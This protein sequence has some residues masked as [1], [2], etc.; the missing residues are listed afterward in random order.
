MSG[1]QKGQN[2]AKSH[3]RLTLK[4]KYIYIFF[5]WN[6]PNSVSS[7]QFREFRDFSAITENHWPYPLQEKGGTS[8][9]PPLLMT[10]LHYILSLSFVFSCF[11]R[12]AFSNLFFLSTSIVTPS[13]TRSTDFH[14]IF[15]ALSSLRLSLCPAQSPTT[16]LLIP[17][18]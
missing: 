3:V 16:F 4:K 10:Y 1:Q 5:F 17:H 12:S 9:Q 18:N 14:P 2:R 6:F 8:L 13:A 15:S 7:L 11:Y